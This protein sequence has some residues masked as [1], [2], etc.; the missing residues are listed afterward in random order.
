MAA[1]PSDALFSFPP[2]LPGNLTQR[3]GLPHNHLAVS[4]SS[5]RSLVFFSERNALSAG[6]DPH[7][8]QLTLRL[9]SYLNARGSPE[10]SRTGK[11]TRSPWHRE[12][13]VMQSL[14][15]EQ[16]WQRLGRG[17]A[18]S[19]AAQC[20]DQHQARPSRPPGSRPDPPPSCGAAA[21]TSEWRKRPSSPSPCAPEPGGP[22]PPGPAGWPSPG[23]AWGATSPGR[24]RP[25][26]HEARFR[27][28]AA[29][30]PP[31][32]RRPGSSALLGTCRSRGSRPMCS[33]PSSSGS[34]MPPLCEASANA[35][36]SERDCAW[37]TPPGS[38][39]AWASG[40]PAGLCGCGR[41]QGPGSQAEPHPQ[42]RPGGCSGDGGGAAWMPVGFSRCPPPPAHQGP[43]PASCPQSLPVG[44]PS[45][46]A[47]SVSL[48]LGVPPALP[49]PGD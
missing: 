21:A 34:A 39:L 29:L 36:Q 42:A 17:Q 15:K 46:S 47:A 49:P 32:P 45:V 18:T 8:R 20:A 25:R 30:W 24:R 3:W 7:E 40:V 1:E 28:R 2:S 11:G 26:R 33:K 48:A 43:G 37:A 13:S 22:S 10:L 41:A 12:G 19:V 38:A 23:S 6:A 16:R 44:P 9:Q 35:P 4:S 14:R 5:P 31:P 27:R